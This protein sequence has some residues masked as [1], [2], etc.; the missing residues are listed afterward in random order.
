MVTRLAATYLGSLQ[1]YLASPGED[2]LH[3][4]YELGR[5][6][7]REERSLLDLSIAHHDALTAALGSAPGAEGARI[8]RSAGEFFLE[9]ITAFEMVQRGFREARDAAQLQQ[10]HAEMLRQLS[11]F[12]SDSSLAL[13]AP[14]ALAEM[15]QLVA[16]QAREFV[17]AECCIVTTGTGTARPERSASYPADDLGWRALARW[18]NLSRVD[19]VVWS[20]GGAVRLA[21]WDVEGLLRISTAPPFG[22][23]DVREW[24]GAPLTALGGHQLGAIHL[25][26]KTAGRFTTLDEA[27]AMHLAQM[28]AAAVERARLYGD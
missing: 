27:V 14:D 23:V 13:E 8:V 20:A 11:D 22:A 9:C 12:L 10:R 7:V 17:A 16:E 21:A 6:T 25:V 24:L 5:E 1:Q 2:T 19:E 3:A 15:R 18:A 4:A 28:S 26:N